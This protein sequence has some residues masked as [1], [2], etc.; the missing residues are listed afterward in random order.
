MRALLVPDPAIFLMFVRSTAAFPWSLMVP[1]VSRRRL[2]PCTHQGETHMHKYMW[3]LDN[4][5]TRYKLTTQSNTPR[6]FQRPPSTTRLLLHF[7]LILLY[8]LRPAYALDLLLKLI[9]CARRAR[10]IDSGPGSITQWHC[11]V[12]RPLRPKHHHQKQTCN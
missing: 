6:P 8:D 4:A 9:Q 2:P 1:T 5:S 7:Q 11:L 10:Y 3:T 12:N